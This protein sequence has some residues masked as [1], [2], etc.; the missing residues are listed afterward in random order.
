MRS[1]GR[2][3]CRAPTRTGSSGSAPLSGLTKVPLAESR[4]V[5]I[6]GCRR[7]S[8]W[9][10]RRLT[11]GRSGSRRRDG[12]CG[13]ARSVRPA[14]TG[15]AAGGP[16]AGPPRAAGSGLSCAWAG[17]RR[18]RRG[19]GR[20]VMPVRA[21][22]LEA[23]PRHGVVAASCTG[24][25]QT[26]AV[27]AGGH[28]RP[29]SVVAAGGVGL[30][31]IVLALHELNHKSGCATGPGLLCTQDPSALK[32]HAALAGALGPNELDSPASSTRRG[33]SSSAATSVTAC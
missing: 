27:V 23:G 30:R 15:R 28:L 20:R 5:T 18:A 22:R 26:S 12:C 11:A 17:M 14:L 19:A 3:C 1:S 31:A 33:S 9:H 4:S 32:V 2:S 21:A 6:T 13:S 24:S 25:P 7:W 29:G 16:A 10:C 8:S